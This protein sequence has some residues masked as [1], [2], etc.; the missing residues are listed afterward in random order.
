MRNATPAAICKVKTPVSHQSAKSYALKFLM[1]LLAFLMIGQSIWGQVS[2]TGTGSGNTYTQNFNT[3]VAA[4][5]SGWAFSETGTNANTSFSTGTGTGTGG[6]TYFFGAANEW[7]FGGLLSGSLTPTIGVAFT[8]NTGGA[9]E[10]LVIAY[11]GETW[12]VGSASRSDRLDFQYSTNAT[13]LTTGTWTDVNALDY[14][15]PGQ[16]TGSGSQ[17][18]SANIS[19]TISGLNIANGATVWIRWNDFNASGSDDGMAVDDFSLYANAA[20]PVTYSVTYNGNGNTGGTAPVDGSSPYTAGSN[21]TVLSEGSLVRTGYTF[22]GWNTAANGSG[23]AYASGGTITSIAADITLYAQWAINTYTLTYDG[24]TNDGGTAPTDPNS[25]YNYNTNATVLSEGTLTKTGFS[26]A[27]WNTAANG[28]GTAY[29]PGGT[30]AN[31]VA[32]ITLFAQWIPANSYAVTYDGNGNTGGT[33]PVDPNSP[34]TSGSNVTILSEGSLVRTGYTFTGWNTAANGSGTAYAVNDVISNI[35]ASVTL[36]AQWSINTYTVTY[37]GNTND[38][39]TAP[40]DPNNPYN[41]NSNVTVLGQGTLTKTNYNFTGWNTAS[42]GSGTAYAEAGTIT[43]IAANITLYAQWSIITYTVTYNGNTNT[44]GTAPVDPN[45]PYNI[46]SNVTVLGQGTLVKTGHTFNGWN[47]AADGSG[48]AYAEA[49]TIS[50]LSANTTLFAQWTVNTYTVTYDGNGNTGGTAPVDANSPYNFGSTVTVLANTGSLVRTGFVFAGWNTAADGS[51]TNYAATGSVT[52]TLGAANVV[53]Y[54]RWVVPFYEA[55]DYTAADNIGGTASGSGSNN[56]WT[57][58]SGNGAISVVS[59]SLTYTG[60][61]ASA[62]NKVQIP[63]TNATVTRD[64]NRASSIVGTPTV[65]YYSFLLN[66]INNTQ[67]GTSHTDNGYF[68]H[69]LNGAGASPG[70]VFYGRVSARSVN[71]GANF[72]L[73]IVN[74]ASSY[75]D[76]ATDLSFGTTYLV[77]V[78]YDF[79]GASNDIATIWIN[80]A[81]LGGAEAAGGTSNSSSAA[82]TPVTFGALAIRNASATPNAFID[83][84]R[85]GDTWADVTPT[86]I[87]E[88]TI[89]ATAQTAGGSISPAGAVTV[90]GGDNQTFTITPEVCN[91]IAE[92]IIDGVTSLGAVTEYTFEN[93][94][95]NH[96]IDVYFNPSTSTT[97]TGTVNSNWDEAGNWS[98]CVPNAGLEVTIASGT[99]NSPVLNVDAEVNSLTINDGATLS[100]SNKSLTINGG[101][102]GT[103]LSTLTGSDEASLILNATTSLISSAPIRLKNLVI[104]GGT[105]SLSSAVEIS[106]GTA[107]VDPGE[108]SVLSGALLES[109]GFLTIKS[110]AFGTGRVAQ[111]DDAGNY[112]TGDVTVE[113]YIPNNGFRSWRFL[114]VPTTG[115]QTVR[116]A[117]QEGDVNPSPL[118]NNLPGYGTIITGTGS[119]ATAQAAGFDGVVPNASFLTWGTNAWVN[120]TGTNGPI[121]TTKG[122]MLFLRGDRSQVIN[123]AVTATSSTTLRTKGGLYQGPQAL[124]SFAPNSFNAVGNLYASAIDFTQLQ[125]TGGTQNLFYIWDSKKQSGTSLGAYQTFSSTNGFACLVSGGSYVFGQPN[126]KIESGQAFFV[127]ATTAGTLTLTEASKVADGASLGFRPATPLSSLVKI[128]SRLYAAGSSEIADANVVVFNDKYSNTVAEE[129]AVKMTNMVENF[130]VQQGDKTLAIEG[131]HTV[132]T[133]DEIVFNLWNLKQQAYAF[134]FVP[135]NLQTAGLEAVLEDSYLKT[136]TPVSLETNTVVNFTVDANAASAAANRF[137][138]V[139]NKVKQPAPAKAVYTIAPNPAENGIVNLQFSNKAAGKYSI[140]ILTVAGQPVITR[141]IEHAGGSAVQ[142]IRLGGKAASGNYMVEITAPDKTKTIQSLLV[143]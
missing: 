131:R 86:G 36:F 15:N 88:Y 76:V 21:V 109:N 116:Q 107:T 141:T 42:D 75:T 133:K 80:P 89:T 123:G 27:G 60:L 64:V 48:T 52:F 1:P 115:S 37:D 81:S 94:S 10:G 66:V 87:T 142:T 102:T 90:T 93:V 14:A 124:P 33:A 104:N 105:T 19:S 117:W 69:F 118:Q 35:S 25:P 70:T 126:T 24:N 110:N 51:G 53:L 63:G 26:F 77:V 136:S 9:I 43:G 3:A 40:V 45:S 127:S 61:S 62:G 132:T 135:Q 18:H 78:K 72:R 49:G 100:L 38:G 79:N 16:A 138:I 29:I 55:F 30:I 108:V 128:D 82:I 57:T 101:F 129:D 125:R 67:L 119:L 47:T 139:L 46:G 111:G 22:T 73:G 85:V 112:I 13:S 137:K 56:N 114:S 143:N 134:E 28:S 5:P 130:G 2:L 71:A 106:G 92:V 32:N 122:Y 41:Y 4:V 83:E 113:R 59:G 98:S 7:A 23:T 31:I 97:W 50:S 99:P 20:A 44:G 103:A 58:H 65:A 74:S 12:R 11:K 84:I 54:A 120:S 96:T 6:D 121:A 39:G 140:R 95:A 91:D 34:Y 17:Q 68:M 8:N